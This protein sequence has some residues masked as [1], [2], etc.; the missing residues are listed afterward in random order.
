MRVSFAE[1]VM[2]PQARSADLIALD[3]ALDALAVVDKRK[4]EIVVMRFFG[5]LSV[6]EAAAVL[7]VSPDTIMRDWQLAKAWLYRELSKDG[8]DDA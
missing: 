3:D 1:A 4:S 6:E 5:G 2:V 8:R 7:E